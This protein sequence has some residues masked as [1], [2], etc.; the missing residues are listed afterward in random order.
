MTLDDL[1]EL[2]LAY[3][4]PYASANDPVNLAAFIGQN[5]VSG[6]SPRETA[7]QLKAAVEEAKSA[8]SR[9]FILDVRSRGEYE[10][11][12]IA[13]AVNLPVDGLRY[14]E[15]EGLPR[16]GLIHCRSG[17]RAPPCFKDPKAEGLREARQCDRRLYVR[18]RGG[19]IR[20]GLGKESIRCLV[21]H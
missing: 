20:C 21:Y 11:G 1:A 16:D 17:F 9:A 15:L 4:P 14:D 18:A 8:G 2:D 19:R 7:A 12:H 13:G 3:A 10:A 5:D 6:F